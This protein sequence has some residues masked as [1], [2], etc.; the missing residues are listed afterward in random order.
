MSETP[1]SLCV[2]VPAFNEEANISG[3]SRRVA[4]TLEAFPNP[5]AVIIV[6]DGS[7]D[8]SLEIGRRLAAEWPDRVSVLTHEK[9]QGLG[10][11]LR[12][13]FAAAMADYVTC[14]PADFPVTPEDWAPFAEALGYGGRHRRLSPTT[15]GI[16]SP[17]AIQRLALSQARR[18]TL[19]ATASRRQLDLRLPAG[20][21]RAG[22]DHP[23]RDPDAN[24]D[25]GQAPRPRGDVPG[26]RLP[27]GVANR[28]HAV[29]GE[30]EASCGGP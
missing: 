10:A 15:R 19:R 17:D 12:T 13:G 28:R 25:P 20:A 5:Y 2:V 27:D 16:Q 22:D 21:G 29:G 18:R 6:D 23:E 26:G 9:N 3:L 30:I 8:R 7:R 1:P 14:C 24:R 4:T 11:A